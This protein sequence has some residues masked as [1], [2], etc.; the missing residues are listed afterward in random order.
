MIVTTSSESGSQLRT[1]A[2]AGK[3]GAI[4]AQFLIS[5]RTMIQSFVTI[6]SSSES[7]PS[8]NKSDFGLEFSSFGVGFKNCQYLSGRVHQF[9]MDPSG[10]KYVWARLVT[11]WVISVITFR[12]LISSSTPN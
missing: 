2:A 7:Y 8:W 10:R 12:Y 3:L 9:V 5:F 1:L 11:G 4:V 6:G